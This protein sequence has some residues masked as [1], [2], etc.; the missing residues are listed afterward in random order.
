MCN[1]CRIEYKCKPLKSR[2]MT[3]RRWN[4]TG[5]CTSTRNDR[6]GKVES[7]DSRIW[8]DGLKL[9][10]LHQMSFPTA[11]WITLYRNW[12]AFQTCRWREPLCSRDLASRCHHAWV[13]QAH[14]VRMAM[15]HRK[16]NA[17]LNLVPAWNHPLNL[18]VTA[19]PSS[20]FSS[21]FFPSSSPLRSQSFLYLPNIMTE[22]VLF[23][24]W[25]H[26]Q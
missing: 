18:L 7:L 22:M 25:S 24:R 11:S 1:G 23:S 21:P 15:L 6:K 2:S 16:A 9:A 3:A 12:E 5:G 13:A 10:N 17:A 14:S 26:L 8:E 19:F 20:L 4:W